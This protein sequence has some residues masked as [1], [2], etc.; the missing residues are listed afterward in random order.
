MNWEPTVEYTVFHI[1]QIK[2][3]VSQN[4][5]YS[6]CLQVSLILIIFTSLNHSEC[7]LE[8]REDLRTTPVC[9]ESCKN[10]NYS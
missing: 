4:V 10:R 5:L 9:A 3:T 8:Y 2:D 1:N 6:F 7:T